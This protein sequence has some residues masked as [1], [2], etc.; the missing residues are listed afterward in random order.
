M[1]GRYTAAIWLF[2]ALALSLIAVGTRAPKTRESARHK[3]ARMRLERLAAEVAPIAEDA[4]IRPEGGCLQDR[5]TGVV[6]FQDAQRGWIARVT[7]G[8]ETSAPSVEITPSC[9][10]GDPSGRDYAFAELSRQLRVQWKRQGVGRLEPSTIVYVSAKPQTTFCW[11]RWQTLL[12]PD[13]AAEVDRLNRVVDNVWQTIAK[14]WQVWE[15]NL[16]STPWGPVSRVSPA[17]QASCPQP[18]GWELA[19]REERSIL[20]RPATE[21]ADRDSRT[22][23]ELAEREEQSIL[24]QR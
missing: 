7:G 8:S 15:R 12:A 11:A 3:A 14:Q 22:E 18:M 13:L 9:E 21:L 6:Y 23:V 4:S 10:A 2:A 24:I 5:S 19:E 16:A 17:D 20:V 1:R